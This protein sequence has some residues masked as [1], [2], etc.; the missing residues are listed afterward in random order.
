MLRGI[1]GSDKAFFISYST[2]FVWWP[3]AAQAST[4]KPQLL[5]PGSNIQSWPASILTTDLLYPKKSGPQYNRLQWLLFIYPNKHLKMVAQKRIC[6]RNLF[7]DWWLHIQTLSNNWLNFR[8][9]H[10]SSIMLCWKK[11]CIL[12]S[13]FLTS[14]AWEIQGTV[15]SLRVESIILRCERQSILHSLFLILGTRR[16]WIWITHGEYCRNISTVNYNT[17]IPMVKV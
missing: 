5:C 2:F 4:L 15:Y 14:S 11:P 7:Y 16:A 17:K 1:R 8:V 6:G 10:C 9:L 12:N 3:L 13:I